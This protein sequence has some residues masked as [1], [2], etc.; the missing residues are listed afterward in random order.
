M[1]LASNFPHFKKL[2]SLETLIKS[3]FFKRKELEKI[4]KN[5][6]PL[7]RIYTEDE[8]RKNAKVRILP[9]GQVKVTAFRKGVYK[10]KGFEKLDFFSRYEEELRSRPVGSADAEKLRKLAEKELLEICQEKTRKDNLK[11][12]KDKIFEIASANEW[13]Y[14]ITLTLDKEKINRYSPEEVQKTVCKWFDNQVQRKGFKYLIVPELHEDGAIHFHGLC[15]D[16]LAFDFSGNYKIP[17]KKKPVKESTLRKYGFTPESEGVKKVF[18][19]REF[20]YGFTT[21]LPLDS[22]VMAVSLYMTKYITKDLNKIFGSFYM[23][24]GK[25]K[26]TL[27]FELLDIDFSSLEKFKG[28]RTYDLPEN[29]GQVCYVYTT[30]E[31]L[32]KG[33]TIYER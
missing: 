20:P 13:D 1:I 5:I 7:H 19:I 6:V 17:G 14:M 22:N 8:I 25:I 33:A 2:E 26:R 4:G 23:A 29:Y 30:L 32:T 10:E 27:P 21:A 12:A 16:V 9:N 3:T 28:A 31:E 24:G 11:R 18:N 15:N